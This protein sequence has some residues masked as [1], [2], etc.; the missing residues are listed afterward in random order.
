MSAAIDA[1]VSVLTH[2]GAAVECTTVGAAAE[3]VELDGGVTTG[4]SAVL[5]AENIENGADGVNGEP[6]AA[7]AP[8]SAAGL[9]WKKDGSG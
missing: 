5:T 1:V 6:G 2:A 8:S 9:T 7:A 4:V 3:T